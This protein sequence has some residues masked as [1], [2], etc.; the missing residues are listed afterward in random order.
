MRRPLPPP[1]EQSVGGLLESFYSLASE[2]LMRLREI[3]EDTT[4]PMAEHHAA[5]LRTLE[6]I[7]APVSREPPAGGG[8]EWEQARP[9]TGDAAADRWEQAIARGETPDLEDEG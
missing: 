6:G 9:T 8:D 2:E 7:F 4:H 5:A 1:G 3:A